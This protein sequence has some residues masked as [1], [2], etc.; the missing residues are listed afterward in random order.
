M[1]AFSTTAAIVGGFIAGGFGSIAAPWATW[2]VEKRRLK[3]EGHLALVTQWRAGLEDF[4]ANEAGV[5]ASDRHAE[6][7]TLNT[8]AWFRSLTAHAAPD[9]V[10]QWH[11]DGKATMQD[12]SPVVMP[13]IMV[14]LGAV[15]NHFVDQIST[16]IRRIERS[17]DLT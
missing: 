7:V 1:T 6:F 3:R 5:G 4:A 16:E 2:G 12:N 11:N 8:K 10:A 15:S 17:W 9:A 13:T 14:V